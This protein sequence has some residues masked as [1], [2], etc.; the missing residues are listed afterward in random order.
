MNASQAAANCSSV[1]QGAPLRS[2]ANATKSVRSQTSGTPLEACQLARA[3]SEN[4]FWAPF[5]EGLDLIMGDWPSSVLPGI[6]F[7][8]GTEVLRGSLST[9]LPFSKEVG[10]GLKVPAPLRRFLNSCRALPSTMP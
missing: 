3:K 4:A 8:D 9:N 7:W 6:D 5:G 2:S 1:S 10:A